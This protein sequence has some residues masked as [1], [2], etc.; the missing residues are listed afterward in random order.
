M[1]LLIGLA[2]TAFAQTG[3]NPLT[4]FKNYFVTGDYIVAGWVEGPPDGTGFAQGTISIPDNLQPDQTNNHVPN[5]V[6]KGADIVAAYLYWGTVEGNQSSFAGQQAFFNGY[7]I[8]GIVLGNPKAPVSWSTGGC[9]GAGQGSKTMRMYRADVRPYLP[10]DLDRTSSTFGA[11]DLTNAKIPVR[12]SDSGSNGNTQPFALGASLV[13]IYR[14][15]SPPNPP[16]L[17]A[18]VLYDGSFAPNNVGST[19]TQSMVGFYQSN[20]AVAKLTHIVA[21]GQQNK[22]QQV[23][24]NNMAQPLPSLYGALPPF[25]GIYSQN[26]S[27]WDDPTWVLN[28]YG[29]YVLAD[30]MS[31]STTVMPSATNKGCVNWGAIILS[32]TVQDTDHDG[33]LDI[34][35]QNQ[36]YADLAHIDANGNAPWVAL[37]GADPGTKDLFVEI[38]YFTN[39]DGSAGKVHSHLP[40]QAALDAIGDAFAQ[41]GINVHFDL[42]A[43]IYPND[44][45]PYVVRYPIPLPNPFPKNP[46]LIGTDPPPAGAGGNPISEGQAQLLCQDNLL[47]CA[48]PNQVTTS[49]KGEFKLVQNSSN[50]GDFQPG[51]DQSYRYALFGHAQGKPRSYWSTVAND[52]ATADSQDFGVV[53]LPQLVSIRVSSGTA[54]VTIKSP[55]WIAPGPP[56]VTP[57][58]GLPLVLKPGDNLPGFCS[59]I[60][61]P[62]FCSDMNSDRVTISGS[63]LPGPFT[64]GTTPTTLPLNG[65]YK[66]TNVQC[67]PNQCQPDAN[68]MITT[69]FQITTSINVPDGIYQFSCPTAPTV[70]SCVAEPQ[71]GISYLGPTSSSGHADFG[72]GGDLAVTLGLW[73]FDDP[74]ACDPDPSSVPPYCNDQVG[75]TSEQLGTFMHELGHTLTLTHGGTYY[76]DPNNP[77]VPTYERNCKPNFLSVMNYLF[78]VHGF[79]DG[80]FDYSGQTLPPLNER[81]PPLSESSGVGNDILSNQHAQ[82]LTRW[83]SLAGPADLTLQDG[84]LAHCDGTPIGRGEPFSARVDGTVAPGGNFS[85]PLDWNND[86]I[87]DAVA[88]PGEDLNHNG[89]IGDAPFSG[90]DDWTHIDLQQ[91][92]TRAGGFGSSGGG[93][94]DSGGGG[95]DSGGGGL[96]SGGGG[97]DSGGG[98]LDSGGGGLDS[99]GGGLDSGGGGVEQ[100]EQTAN[101]T[102]DEPTGLTCT[103]AEADSSGTVFPGCT[104]TG[105]YFEKGKGVPLSWNAPGFGQTRSYAIFR[106]VGS[107]QTRQQVLANI[108]SFSKI[109]TLSGFPPSTFTVDQVNLKK[110]TYTYFVTDSNKFGANS[111]FSAPIVVTLQ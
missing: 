84:P 14:V 99:G 77:G 35:E 56:P 47:L 11:P 80:G 39:L 44:P 37:P 87:I 29:S 51:R 72:G 38:D 16:P 91:T 31:E 5:F 36:G 96:D 28:S 75:T 100:D 109:L 60:Q 9:S 4:I 71:L 67:S 46:L 19:M 17:N 81:A 21:N 13:V 103:N 110:T 6:P 59:S 55:T 94:L 98:G 74:P 3:N 42:G 66:F 1:V 8:I 25:P 97:L 62:A 52:F 90:F 18:I 26:G 106:A 30:D 20:A 12:L 61:K 41:Q 92:N 83:Y 53:T 64:P 32:T 85:A 86:L 65:T 22:Q 95:L 48:F 54:T 68:G 102:A 63:L 70:P 7:K 76:S 79:V 24:L 10:R 69:T 82:H 49:W 40:K 78:Q 88:A 93:G 111:N 34:W 43:N 107:F 15:L 45:H 57:A 108:A 23:F 33:L 58:N 73:G 2:Q 27:A 104:G 105:P 89:K 50:L 101:S